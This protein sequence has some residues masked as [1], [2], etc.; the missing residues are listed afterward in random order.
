MERRAL[1]KLVSRFEITADQ[2]S[3]VYVQEERAK[4]GIDR[5]DADILSN[6]YMLYEATRLT[7]DPI[8]VW[9]VDR[10]AFPDEVIRKNHPLPEPTALDADTDARRVRA[11]SVSALEQAERQHAAAAG[12]GRAGDSR[13]CATA[14]MRSRR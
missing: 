10:G 12:S 14:A 4:A 6:P 5:T 11:L 7:A 2:A 9:T 13:S 1:L 3:T 8:S